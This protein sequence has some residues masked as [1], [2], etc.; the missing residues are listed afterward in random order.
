LAAGQRDDGGWE[1]NFRSASPIGALEW[2]GYATVGA[3]QVLR[4]NGHL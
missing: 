3:I 4:A 1:V 2:R